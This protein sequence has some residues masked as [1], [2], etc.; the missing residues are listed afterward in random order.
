MGK[1]IY[2]R[3]APGIYHGRGADYGYAVYRDGKC[4]RLKI[5]DMVTTAGV[6]HCVGQRVVGEWQAETKTL[7]VAIAQAYDDLGIDYRMADH[8]YRTHLSEAVRIAYDAERAARLAQFTESE[9]SPS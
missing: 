9:S 4:W 6:R 1:V 7:A 3:T 2:S 8:G 5:R